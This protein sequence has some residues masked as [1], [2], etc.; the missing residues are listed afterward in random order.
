[1]NRVKLTK[2]LVEGSPITDTELVLWDTEVPGFACKITPTG[3]RTYFV[4][5]RNQHG[6]QRKPTIGQHSVLTCDDARAIARQWLADAARGG[7]PSNDK[8]SKRKA[9]TM[10][11][12]CQKY[13][14]EYAAVHKKPSSFK[15][16][17]RLIMN[18]VLP[19]LGRKQ[20]EAIRRSDVLALQHTYRDAPYECNRVLA[21]LSKMFN[22]A[23]AWGLRPDGSNPCRHVKKFKEHKRERFLTPDELA[24]V[25]LV[26]DELEWGGLEPQGYL[27]AIRLLAL[28]GCRLGEI[29]GLRWDQVDLPRAAIHLSDAK[30]GARTVPLGAAAIDAL[31]R[32]ERTD[33]PWVIRGARPGRKPVVG[34]VEHVWQR[35][36]VLA[37]LPG[38]RLHDFRHT[39]GT[40]SGQ[41]GHN[42]FVV[43]DLLGHKTLAMTGRY[44]ERDHDP[45][46]QAADEVSARI[47]D[48]MN[49]M[50]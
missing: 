38:V 7:D 20:V 21:L 29:V 5:Y 24:R 19:M 27:D 2:R 44:V 23:E 8:R 32:I 36:R 12:L 35:V 37:D 18:K 39:V 40:Y 42:A 33:D 4:Y 3:K 30:A 9:A 47:A 41:A 48:A 14:T 45:L 25:G 34:S 28:T 46:R 16:D 43:R 50:V 13:L 11:E 31:K 10:K 17:E 49:G 26:L 6:Q 1:M 22:L 15:Q